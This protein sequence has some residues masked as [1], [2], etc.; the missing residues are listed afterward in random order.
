MKSFYILG[1]RVN[2]YKFGLG[3]IVGF[4]DLRGE[5]ADSGK[6]GKAV[7]TEHQTENNARIVVKLDNPERWKFAPPGQ[8]DPYMMQND[9]VDMYVAFVYLAA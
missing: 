3:T 1:Q 5:I 9:L 4:E 8:P 6:T 2:T 7:I